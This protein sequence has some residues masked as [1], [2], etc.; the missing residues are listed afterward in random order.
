MP[1]Y[2][3]SGFSVREAMWHDPENRWTIDDYPEDWD[4][5]RLKAGLM[6]EPKAVG[7]YSVR[8]RTVITC[9]GCG[10]QFGGVHLSD[11]AVAENLDRVESADCGYH[12]DPVISKDTFE[13]LVP[14]TKSKLIVRDDT[15]LELGSV[16][17]G[18]QLISHGVMGEILEAVL[19]QG[20]KFETAGSCKDGAQVWALAYLDEPLTVANDDTATYPFVALLNSHDGSGACK[21]VNT[22][23]RVVCW[24][25]YN[26]ASM[27]G[28]KTGR[29]FVFRHTAGVLDR[30]EEAKTAIAGLRAESAAWA[31]MAE[32]LYK[33]RA[34]D[35]AVQ[36]FVQTFIPE[37]AADVVSE[38]VRNNITKARATFTGL[39]DGSPT[40]DGHRGTALGLVD[41]AVEYLDHVRGYR[42]RDTYMGRTLLRPE[43]LK[44]RAVT[45]AL[46]AC[47][48]N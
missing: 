42:N 20:L 29:Q 32:G 10:N 31:E 14:S 40:T 6:W 19:G 27:E 36:M 13:V 8:P 47:G 39:Y 9:T 34:D 30:V 21:L 3:D 12:D 17:S 15:L 4:D 44:A 28:D 24:N 11:C 46:E 16:G 2:F 43:P 18:F 7:A 25:T 37:P 1:A 22:S 23:V 41:A 38:R 5:A 48:A 45:M 26:M 35:A 33:V